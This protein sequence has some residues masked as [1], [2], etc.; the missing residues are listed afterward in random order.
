MKIS[1]KKKKVLIW[2]FV[3]ILVIVLLNFF[4]KEVRSFFYS[5]SSPIQKV[6]FEAG[7]KTSDFLESIIEAGDLKNETNELKLK[8]Q[9][10][11]AQVVA[12]NELKK[13]NKILREALEIELQK[14]FKLALSQIIGKD[15]SQDF[16]LINKGSED[17]ISE[18][19]PAVTQQRI[20]VGKISEVY[21]NFSKVMLISN[22]ESSFDAKISAPDG[23]PPEAGQEDNISGIVKGK[24]N[25]KVSFDLVLREEDIFEGDIVVTSALG[26]IFPKALLVGK[27]KTIK[28]IDI[29]QFQQAEI[30]P[31]FDIS[32]AENIFIIL[33]F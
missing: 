18:G 31:F 33:D 19:M 16:I 5:V 15:I 7:N 25:S 32:D 30:E 10:L 1:F 2:V 20:L 11:L 22:K 6:L 3:G 27:I 29:E 23:P 26:G 13:E 9:E 17:G 21:E 8:N 12:L 4:Q 28:K 24:G 14:D